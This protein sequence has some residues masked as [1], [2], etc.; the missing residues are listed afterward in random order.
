LFDEEELLR[1]ALLVRAV[2]QLIDYQL[3][4]ILIDYFKY[5]LQLIE[6]RLS[7]SISCCALPRCHHHLLFNYW[8]NN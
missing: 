3:I 8:S 1:W 4:A 5:Q 6:A 2:N 7:I